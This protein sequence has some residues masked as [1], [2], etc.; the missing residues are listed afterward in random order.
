MINRHFFHKYN[1][2]ILQNWIQDNRQKQGTGEE[3]NNR[4]DPKRLG[5]SRAHTSN[6]KRQQILP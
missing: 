5:M 2:R 4:G 3:S 1:H 6:G